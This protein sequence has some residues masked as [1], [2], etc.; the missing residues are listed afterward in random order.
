MHY[1]E[2]ETRVSMKRTQKEGS[3]VDGSAVTKNVKFI[4]YINIMYFI[5]YYV[6][7]L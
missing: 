7:L 3:I 4:Y 5:F 2:V 1:L 6:Y